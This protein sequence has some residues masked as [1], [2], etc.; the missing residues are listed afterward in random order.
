[1]KCKIPKIEI[2]ENEQKNFP[3]F[4]FG[5]VIRTLVAQAMQKKHT[6]MQK[7]LMGVLEATTTKCVQN[8]TIHSLRDCLRICCLSFAIIIVIFFS[9]PILPLPSTS[10][11]R[12]RSI[13][14]SQCVRLYLCPFL[15]LLFL[16]SFSHRYD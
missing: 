15:F 3:L 8:T 1:M 13:P 6:K 16:L 11:S 5:I 14:F 10:A 12:S 7:K 4:L 9:L 2:K